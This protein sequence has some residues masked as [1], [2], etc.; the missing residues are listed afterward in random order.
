MNRPTT[1]EIIVVRPAERQDCEE[2]YNLSCAQLSTAQSAEEN[3]TVPQP[4][5][6]D[7][8]RPARAP[9]PRRLMSAKGEFR[10]V[11]DDETV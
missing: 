9:R 6:Q 8:Q 5:T 4:Q 7:E 11:R 3:Q 1:T 10:V 2:I